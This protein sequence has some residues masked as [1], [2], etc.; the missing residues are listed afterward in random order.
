MKQVVIVSGKGGTGKTTLSASLCR[1]IPGIT[2]AD[3]DVDAA[4][5]HLVTPHKVLQTREYMGGKKAAIDNTKCTSCGRCMEYCR[6][7]AVIR[8]GKHFSID[9]SGCEGC[10]V[11]V[12][13]CPAGAVTLATVK[14]G[15]YTLNRAADFVFS[16]GA[17]DPGEE[18]SG[19]LVT[20]VRKEAKDYA[21]EHSVPLIL[22]DGAPG[23][24]CPAISSLT[25]ADH[26]VV[27][28]EPGLSALHDMERMAVL[29]SRMAIP[30]SAVINKCDIS[31]ALAG[32]VEKF[33][34]E[35][36]IRIIGKIPFDPMVITAARN[37]AAVIDYDCPAGRAVRS[38]ADYLNLIINLPQGETA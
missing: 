11:C 19:G 30:W 20:K 8:K 33:C 36:D 12:L 4:N 5:L 6:F 18:T 9:R 32:R 2:A 25:G 3:C 22:A 26:A 21:A 16:S 31:P 7:D 27:I 29:L 34:A 37:G 15:A 1:L 17:L 14:A 24:A 28:T 23:I 38:A 35:N 10:G 13:V